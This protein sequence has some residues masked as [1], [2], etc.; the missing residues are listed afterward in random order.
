[1]TFI[2]KAIISCKAKTKGLEILSIKKE[3][4]VKNNNITKLGAVQIFQLCHVKETSVY[5]MKSRSFLILSIS[6]A[7]LLSMVLLLASGAHGKQP[8]ISSLPVN[9][10]SIQESV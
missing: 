1:M 9:I 10:Q 6:A 3:V 8:S 5:L 7:W 4:M 2:K